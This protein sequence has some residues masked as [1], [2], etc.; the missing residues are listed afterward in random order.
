E[1]GLGVEAPR[2]KVRQVG[3]TNRVEQEAARGRHSPTEY[4]AL[5]VENRSEAC[6]GLPQPAPELRQRLSCSRISTGDERS[7]VVTDQLTP[8]L[9]GR[10]ESEADATGIRDLVRHAHERASRPVLLDAT[11]GPA[12]ARQATRNHPQVPELGPRAKSA[13]EERSP[14]N[15]RPAHTGAYGEHRHVGGSATCSEPELRPTGG[16][17]VV[18]DRDGKV[19]ALGE[20]S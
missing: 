6:A 18:V 20:P 2:G 16:V 12:P 3:L 13:A 7:D 11:P 1:L 17:G 8:T 15:D 10:G 5:W 19:D 9:T 4:K 14:R